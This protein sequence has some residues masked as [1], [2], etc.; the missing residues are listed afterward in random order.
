MR[1]EVYA[2]LAEHQMAFD[3]QDTL[4]L[5]PFVYREPLPIGASTRRAS[6]LVSEGLNDI[7]NPPHATRAAAWALGIPPT[8]E[9][10]VPGI[11][12]E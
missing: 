6:V 7:Q 11:A 8:P 9:R 3:P 10:R 4:N 5:A 2:I 1:T 12:R